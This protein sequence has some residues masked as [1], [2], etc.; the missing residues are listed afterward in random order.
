MSNMAWAQKQRREGNEQILWLQGRNRE[1]SDAVREMLTYLY[2]E[3]YLAAAA[4]GEQ[5]I[6][7]GNDD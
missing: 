5:A 4:I 2:E 1:L 6:L 7:G 3:N